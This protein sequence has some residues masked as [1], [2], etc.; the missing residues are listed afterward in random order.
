[1]RTRSHNRQFWSSLVFALLALVGCLACLNWFLWGFTPETSAIAPTGA[2]PAGQTTNTTEGGDI[3]PPT[4]SIAELPQTAG[5]PLFFANRRPADRTLILPKVSATANV[6]P[7]PAPPAAKP[8]P[9][10]QIRLLGIVRVG[11]SLRALIRPSAETNGAWIGIGDRIRGWQ[12][13]E[14]GSDSATLEVNGQ[15]GQIKLQYSGNAQ[16]QLPT[17]LPR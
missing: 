15:S 16:P 9:L 11:N 12:L 10:E 3:D 14:I 8:Y 4:R 6:P 7:P 13:K 17:Q 1:M 5:R 2:T